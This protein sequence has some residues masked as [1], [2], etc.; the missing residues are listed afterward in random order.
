MM[1]KLVQAK[2][3]VEELLCCHFGIW[4]KKKKKKNPTS[5]GTQHNRFLMGLSHAWGY[6][7]VSCIYESFLCS[8]FCGCFCCWTC[9]WLCSVRGRLVV[10]ICVCV[11]LVWFLC[12]ICSSRSSL[13]KLNKRALAAASPR[14]GNQ[15]LGVDRSCS[16]FFFFFLLLNPTR[17]AVRYPNTPHR[18]IYMPCIHALLRSIPMNEWAVNPNTQIILIYYVDRFCYEM[19]VKPKSNGY[20]D[21]PIDVALF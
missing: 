21:L 10:C 13:A 5:G 16:K 12:A 15:S 19:F 17:E 7:S 2:F 8:F 11:A 18:Y 1:M 9:R 6:M 4:K 14:F 3:G 20:L